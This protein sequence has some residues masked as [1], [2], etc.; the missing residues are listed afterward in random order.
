VIK[1]S[2]NIHGKNKKEF[3]YLGPSTLYKYMKF[4]D[5]F[6]DEP[7]LRFSPLGE[8]NDPFEL[9][10]ACV[11]FL[12]STRQKV[13]ASYPEP[14][15]PSA[16]RIILAKCFDD[17]A[18]EATALKDYGIL[19]L[20]EDP[21]HILMWSHYAHQHKGMAVGFDLS[22][23]F[24]KQMFISGTEFALPVK[25][26]NQRPL[27]SMEKGDFLAGVEGFLGTKGLQWVRSAPQN[28]DRCDSYST[29]QGEHTCPRGKIMPR[30]LRPRWRW[31]LFPAKKPSP[32]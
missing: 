4:R 16:E 12:D 14:L 1:L 29:R 21:E 5:S 30:H 31:P 27:Y 22:H 28:S 3:R 32:N 23:E 26:C 7:V 11:D 10:P 18:V 2:A 9:S 25:Y 13:R 24:F 19:S 20:T 15:G 17:V 6:F 8:L